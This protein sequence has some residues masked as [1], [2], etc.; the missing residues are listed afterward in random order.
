M[1][2]THPTVYTETDVEAL[3]RIF[4]S[5]NRIVLRCASHITL[6]VSRRDKALAIDLLSSA[7]IDLAMRSGRDF[8]MWLA[9]EETI[10]F[11]LIRDDQLRRLIDGLRSTPRLDDHWVN[12]FLKKAMQRAP[13]TVL[14]LAKARIDASI[15]SDDWSIQ[16]LGS[17]FRDSDALDLL[18]LPDGVTQLRDL[19]EWALGRIGDYKFSYRFAEMLQSLCSPYD[20]TCVATIEDWL[21]AGGTADHFKVVTAIVRDAGAGFVFDNERFIARSLGAARAVGRKVFKDLSSAIF[22]TS[23]GGL[24]SGSPGQPFEADL[25]LKDLAEKRLARI[26]RAD[27][28]YD[29]YADIKGHATQDI[30][31]QLADGRRMDEEDADA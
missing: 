28:T 22:A 21:I 9:H 31:R 6:E 10:P 12:A 4:R 27:P 17:V 11:A 29:L 24:R 7:N 8:F 1:F 3:Y 16:P 26:T 15:A 23:V 14:E 13:G 18:A 30:E 2:A 5:E 25:R 20:A 19:L